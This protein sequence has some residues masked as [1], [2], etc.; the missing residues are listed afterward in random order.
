MAKKQQIPANI[1]KLFSKPQYE[2]GD[3]VCF[4]WM[5]TKYYGFIKKYKIEHEE[6]RY[7]VTANGISYPCGLQVK[8]YKTIHTTVGLIVHDCADTP[9]YIRNRATKLNEGVATNTSRPTVS[10]PTPT[11]SSRPVVSNND[12]AISTSSKRPK[13]SS[14][15][16][17]NNVSNVRASKTGLEKFIKKS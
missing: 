1:A 12:S 16:N 11:K 10:N 15:K 6:V 5:N 8:T 3:A 2:I 4:L 13:R 7:F 17:D 14:T 9:E